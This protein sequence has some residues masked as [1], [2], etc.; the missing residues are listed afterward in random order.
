LSIISASGT[1]EHPIVIRGVV[2]AGEL[3][4]KTWEKQ[5]LPFIDCSILKCNWFVIL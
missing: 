1:A 4:K 3:S 5:G 2:D